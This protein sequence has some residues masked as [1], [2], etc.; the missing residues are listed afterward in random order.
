MVYR[1]VVYFWLTYTM[2]IYFFAQ[3]TGTFVAAGSVSNLAWKEEGHPPKSGPINLPKMRHSIAR[4]RCRKSGSTCASMHGAWSWNH[5]QKDVAKALFI[6]GGYSLRGD[7]LHDPSSAFPMALRLGRSVVT[8]CALRIPRSEGKFSVSSLVGLGEWAPQSPCAKS[9]MST[10]GNCWRSFKI[11]R[12]QMDGFSW[13]SGSLG[14]SKTP[15]P[16]MHASA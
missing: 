12:R 10:P 11:A 16:A 6:A 9:M 1:K 14:C 15:K 8:W 3:H 13:S 7:V 5:W 2:V 4:Q